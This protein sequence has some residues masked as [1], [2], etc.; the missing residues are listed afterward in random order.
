MFLCCVSQWSGGLR[1]G[2]QGEGQIP[3]LAGVGRMQVKISKA[4]TFSVLP[5]PVHQI[6]SL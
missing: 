4:F 2:T 1:R 3:R 5:A 6:R